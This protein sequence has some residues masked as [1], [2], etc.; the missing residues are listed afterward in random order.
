[1]SEHRSVIPSPVVDTPG[2]EL[3][4][5]ILKEISLESSPLERLCRCCRKLR[6]GTQHG[7]DRSIADLLAGEACAALC[8]S[9]GIKKAEETKNILLFSEIH[10][11][12]YPFPTV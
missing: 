12:Q 3:G 6:Y 9:R 10:Y 11:H 7:N 5:G 1:H 4:P 2:S 8:G